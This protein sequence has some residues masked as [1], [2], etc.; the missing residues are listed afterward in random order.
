MSAIFDK[1]PD[2]TPNEVFLNLRKKFT[3]LQIDSSQY[4]TAWL[5]IFDFR[6]DSLIFSNAGHNC[7]PLISACDNE[8]AEY[9]LASGRMISNIIEPD[10]YIE[11]KIR[12]KSGDKILF[13]TDGSIEAKNEKGDEFGLERL[14]DTFSKSGDLAY[15]NSKIS[16]YN[17]QAIADD[18]TL[19][20][21]EYE[22]K[23]IK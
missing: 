16:S 9:L 13:F 7:P 10:K 1:H 2:F 3:R 22:K 18:L 12:L 4:F 19:A 8:E 21:I 11:K 5:G 20:L 17:W 23:E 6:D 14:R 15:V